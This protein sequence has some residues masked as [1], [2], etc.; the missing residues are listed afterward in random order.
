MGEA[1]E[2]RCASIRQLRQG[3]PSATF[4]AWGLNFLAWSVNGSK[5]LDCPQQLG[6]CLRNYELGRL[7]VAGDGWPVHGQLAESQLRSRHCQTWG[8]SKRALLRGAKGGQ[9]FLRTPCFCGFAL[10]NLLLL[11]SFCCL[12]LFCRALLVL[13][14]ARL[15]SCPLQLG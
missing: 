12:L 2:A 6:Q 3:Q 8:N 15:A 14:P 11:R 1:W 10:R 13:L 9:Q 5:P 7:R 4:I